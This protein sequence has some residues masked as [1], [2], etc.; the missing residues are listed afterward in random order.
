MA[1]D[2]TKRDGCTQDEILLAIVERLINAIGELN[3][4]NCWL[5]DQPIP[6]SIPGGRFACTVSLGSGRFPNEFFAGGGHDTLVEDG[7]IVIT[8]LVVNAADRPRR[9]WRKIVGGDSACGAPSCLYFKHAILKAL[10]GRDASTG[11]VWQPNADERPLLR[12]MLSPLS[13][14]SP[15][16][17]AVGDTVATAMQMKFSTVFDWDLA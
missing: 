4:Q 10:L 17:V 8:P 15:H 14:D 12:D 13:C 7:S 11:E 6:L 2:P 1:I 9:K 5:A 16:D 3:D